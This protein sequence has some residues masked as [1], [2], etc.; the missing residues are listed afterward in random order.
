MSN[1]VKDIDIRKK[2]LDTL[3]SIY[4]YDAETRI[5][6]E[7]GICQG[8]ARIDIAVV[9]GL[10][11]GYE[12]K[13]EADTLERLPLQENIYSR[14]FDRVTAV[15]SKNHTDK[16]EAIIP[17]WWGLWEARDTSADVEFG[18]IKEARN[19]PNIDSFSLAQCLWRDEAIEIL[20]NNQVCERLY[21]TKRVELW[22][23]LTEVLPLE[24]LRAYVRH[25]L[26]SRKGW[27]IVWPQVPGGD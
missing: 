6:Q 24:E 27:S 14:I 1:I 7:F 8:I 5:L 3:P 25:Y 12:I 15:V 18:V 11:I 13:S 2:L 23:M 9:N 4:K 19:N 10:L 20:K 16:L 26:K 21:K 17:D 22:K